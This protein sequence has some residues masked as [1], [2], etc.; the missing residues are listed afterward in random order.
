MGQALVEVIQFGG[1]VDTKYGET[2]L[3]S[4]RPARASI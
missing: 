2:W 4:N 1:A 3:L